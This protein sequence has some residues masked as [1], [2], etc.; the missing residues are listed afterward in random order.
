MISG[1]LA[2]SHAQ[3]VCSDTSL[4]HLVAEVQMGNENLD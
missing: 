3:T 4:F 1:P 2:V